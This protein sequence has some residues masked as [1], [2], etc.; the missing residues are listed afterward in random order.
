MRALFGELASEIIELIM[1]ECDSLAFFRLQRCSSQLRAVGRAAA[2]QRIARAKVLA[3]LQQRMMARTATAAWADPAR[4]ARE[5][6]AVRALAAAELKRRFLHHR[7]TRMAV[8]HGLVAFAGL[9]AFNQPIAMV[10]RLERLLRVTDFDAELAAAG[11]Y[12]PAFTPGEGEVYCGS[13]QCCFGLQLGAR[14]LRELLYVGRRWY[15]SGRASQPLSEPPYAGE[16]AYSEFATAADVERLWAGHDPDAPD[17]D[18]VA[19]GGDDGAD[20]DEDDDDD[21]DAAGAATTTDA[22]TG[23][24]TTDDINI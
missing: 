23:A 22:A 11:P 24:A 18:A 13:A 7:G 8:E 21:D 5:Q 14:Q 19:H 2:A 6:R 9:P 15:A 12:E 17:A 3:A 10:H 16:L 1:A 4:R 20:S